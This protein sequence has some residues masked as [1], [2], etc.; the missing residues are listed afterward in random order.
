VGDVVE[1]SNGQ[2][3]SVGVQKRLL[4]LDRRQ[5]VRA[6]NRSRGLTTHTR[7]RFYHGGRFADVMAVVEHYN[8]VLK[9]GL[10]D[11]EKRDLVEYLKSL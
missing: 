10:S 1:R 11:A 5:F 9:L 7:G 8:E 4:S 3:S 6:R 2:L